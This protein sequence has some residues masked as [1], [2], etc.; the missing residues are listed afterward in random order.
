MHETCAWTPNK[1]FLDSPGQAAV[2]PQSCIVDGWFARTTRQQFDFEQSKTIL[3]KAKQSNAF[4][5]SVT[6]S[7]WGIGV[8]LGG[9]DG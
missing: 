1:V 8:G 6:L 3:S 2:L 4:Y 7:I 5:N 9:V